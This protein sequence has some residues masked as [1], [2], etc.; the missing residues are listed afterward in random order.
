MTTKICTCCKKAK[1]LT[2]F[3]KHK[4][5]KHGR[6][7]CCIVC[8]RV[9]RRKRYAED[10]DYRTKCKELSAMNRRKSNYTPKH[11]AYLRDWRAATGNAKKRLRYA[12]NAAIRLASNM[13]SSIYQTL[14]GTKQGKKWQHIL[15]YTVDELKAHLQ[16]RFE[17]GMTWDNYGK[18]WHIDHIV[19][20]SFFRFK[21]VTDSE[22]RY[23]W[24]PDNLMPRFATT[25]V[26]RMF[27]SSQLGNINK[28]TKK[29]GEEE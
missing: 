18:I 29:I 16:Q 26:A 6:L 7:A 27:G 11:N 12:T 24:S 19:P 1:P 17:P 8:N 3:H 23:C 5:G 22:F 10:V 13:G 2:A 4:R 21:D 28:S 15:G 14:R 9:A 20:R 25:K